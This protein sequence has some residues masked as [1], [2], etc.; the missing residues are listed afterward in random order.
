VTDQRTDLHTR[1]HAACAD[2]NSAGSEV[3]FTEVAARTGISRATLYRRRELR[4]LIDRHRARHGQALTLTALA[5]QIDHLRQSLE[6][7]AASVRR[8]EEQLRALNRTTRQG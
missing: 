2:L 8:H 5:T 3:T 4:E 1:V 7:V 6:A